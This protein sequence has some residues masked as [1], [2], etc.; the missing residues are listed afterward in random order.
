MK[1]PVKKDQSRQNKPE[2][3]A[4]STSVRKKSGALA[5]DKRPGSDNSSRSGLEINERAA[6]YEVQQ[7]PIAGVGSVIGG[8]KSSQRNANPGQLSSKEA[9]KFIHV[10]GKPVL[11]TRLDEIAAVRNGIDYADF[12]VVYNLFDFSNKKWAEILGIGER[13]VQLLLKEKKAIDSKKSEKL[14]AFVLFVRKGLHVFE[15]FSRFNDWLYYKSPALNG[16]AP[17]DYL[18]TI[19]G[20]E[21]LEEQLFAIET[22]NLA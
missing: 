15:D 7:I 3:K 18:D 17:I 1:P 22:G 20:I 12:N 19:Q 2:K 9:I 21:M 6:Q 10:F 8:Q 11:R 14:I 4:A 5:P 13:S 16:S